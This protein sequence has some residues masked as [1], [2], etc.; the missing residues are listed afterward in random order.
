MSADPATPEDPATRIRPWQ[1][2][3]LVYGLLALTLVGLFEVV[4]FDMRVLYEVPYHLAC[5]WVIHGMQALPPLIADWRS[6]LLPLAALAVAGWMLH[7][8][9]RWAIRAEERNQPWRRSHTLA[10]MAL[11]L[12]GYGAA[13]TLLGIAHQTTWLLGEGW[14]DHGLGIIQDA[15]GAREKSTMLLTALEE[16]HRIHG[17]YPESL[18]ELEMPPNDWLLETGHG[19]S[20][21][22][23]IYLKPDG[24]R[25]D[26]GNQPLI[27]S[28]MI[29]AGAGW[30]AVGFTS[31]EIR[32]ISWDEFENLLAP[33]TPA[34]SPTPPAADE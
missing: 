13:I 9:I 33:A 8:F 7:R 5:G 18:R 11:L 22:P 10:A 32:T 19:S 23:M 2:R 26:D 34:S 21:E 27:I 12:L 16:F 17:R 4:V 14:C 24:K 1:V 25:P 6:A 30:F 3:R 28:P 15:F 29:G 31:M 20:L